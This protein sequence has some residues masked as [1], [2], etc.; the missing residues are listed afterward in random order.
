MIQLYPPRQVSADCLA[1]LRA[2]QDEVDVAGDYAAQVAKAKAIWSSRKQNK[3][4]EEIIEVLTEMCSGAR[5]CCYCEDSMADEVEH[6]DPKDF[7]PEYTFVWENYLFACGPCN[8]PKGNQWAIFLERDGKRI[9]F[10]LERKM[11]EE[12]VAPEKG[13]ALLINPRSENPMALLQLNLL[14]T[15]SKLKFATLSG[16][17]QSE[18]FHRAKYT[19]D[20]LR[21]NTRE[22]LCKARYIAYTAYSARLCQYAVQKANGASV[23]RLDKMRDLLKGES[24]PTVWCEIVR[25]RK[26]G[27]LKAVDA[28]FDSYFDAVPEAL[29]W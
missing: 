24:H 5:R 3:P 8:G 20:V 1:K 28:D 11:G 4:F 25:Y 12:L 9:V 14:T 26:N 27:W 16:D 22:D 6:I 18:P 29:D 21:L 7:F 17:D 2:Y 19:L 13:D 10:H 23:Q 15:D